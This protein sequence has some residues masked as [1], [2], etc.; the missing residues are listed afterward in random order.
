MASN[1]IMETVKR[2]QKALNRLYGYYFKR[3][4]QR[5]NIENRAFKLLDK[6]EAETI[7]PKPAPHEP[8]TQ[9][10]LRK[11]EKGLYSAKT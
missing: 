5:Y 6:I 2:A 4:V 8:I 3:P 7:K 1:L 11:I 9:Q 10:I